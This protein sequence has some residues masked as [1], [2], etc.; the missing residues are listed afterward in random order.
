MLLFQDDQIPQFRSRLYS[1]DIEENADVNTE[2]GVVQATDRDLDPNNKFAFSLTGSFE[3]LDTFRIDPMSGIISIR[4]PLDRERQDVYHITAQVYSTTS[5]ISRMNDT[6]RVI[7]HITDINDNAPVIDFP[8]LGNRTVNISNRVPIGYVVTQIV[9]HDADFSRNGKV[10]YFISEGNEDGAFNIGIKTGDLYVNGDLTKLDG[11][12]YRLVIMAQDDGIPQRLTAAILFV[13]INSTIFYSPLGSTG[14]DGGGLDDLHLIIVI[15]MVVVALIVIILL[16]ACIIVFVL[17]KDRCCK[18]RKAGVGSTGVK[19][20]MP[21]GE[22]LPTDTYNPSTTY[23]CPTYEASTMERH[24]STLERNN[25][26]TLERSNMSTL[27]R[28]PPIDIRDVPMTMIDTNNGAVRGTINHHPN[29]VLRIH[30]SD[31]DDMSVS[32]SG[33]DNSKVRLEKFFHSQR[34]THDFYSNDNTINRYANEIR[35]CYDC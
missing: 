35:S 13:G 6:A 22:H 2:V 23:D 14:S 34:G 28:K 8:K 29:G 21:R 30:E 32:N 27:E 1:F 19:P 25:M 15:V 4:R 24:M 11:H 18:T 7:I 9:A 12:L 33:S 16:V 5:G 26:S 17:K 20:T 31:E 10:T 3:V